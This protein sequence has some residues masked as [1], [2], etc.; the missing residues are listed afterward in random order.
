MIINGETWSIKT[1]LQSKKFKFNTNIQNYCPP[2]TR[3]TASSIHFTPSKQSSINFDSSLNIIYNNCLCK[4]GHFSLQK[5]RISLTAVHNHRN[6]KSLISICKLKTITAK[7]AN[8]TF[9]SPAVSLLP[10]NVVNLL[11]VSATIT[12]PLYS[13]TNTVS[14]YLYKTLS[15]S[16]IWQYVHE[17]C[18]VTLRF[19]TVN[20]VSQSFTQSTKNPH[21]V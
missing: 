3:S 4:S 11:T 13:T 14:L 12:Q 1:W 7:C 20:F 5:P 2:M 6:L 16:T 18:Y 21:N 19:F 8:I 9:P 17:V 15:A 10:W